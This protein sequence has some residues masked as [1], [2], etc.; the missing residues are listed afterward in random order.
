MFNEIMT[1]TDF[2]SVLPKIDPNPQ[3]VGS[4]PGWNYKKAQAYYAGNLIQFVD[5]SPEEE[6]AIQAFYEGWYMATGGI[7]GGAVT[8]REGWTNFDESRLFIRSLLRASGEDPDEGSATKSFYG[9]HREPLAFRAPQKPVLSWDLGKSILNTVCL[10]KGERRYPRVT[11][12]KKALTCLT[13]GKW[14]L[15]HYF[16]KAR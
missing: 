7:S 10:L 11:T 9:W 13:P 15:F 4:A 1:V 3:I 6:L 14:Y 8:L 5:P 12:T 16:G 2:E